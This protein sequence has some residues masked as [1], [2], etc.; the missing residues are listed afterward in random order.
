MPREQSHG[1]PTGEGE[2]VDCLFF[3]TALIY[4]TNQS[5]ST[6]LVRQW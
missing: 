6:T 1:M 3:A 5:R 4:V 2:F